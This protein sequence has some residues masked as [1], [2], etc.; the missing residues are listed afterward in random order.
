MNFQEHIYFIA[1]IPPQDICDEINVFKND[2]KNRFHS[3][4]ALKIVPHIT[5]KPPFKLTISKHE[6]L[7]KWF[8]E[9]DF[10][11]KP[12]LQVLDGFG[13]FETSRR[14]VVFV[15]PVMNNSLSQ[16]QQ[17]LLHHF[18]NRFSWIEVRESDRKFKPHITIGYRDLDHRAYIQAWQE[19]KEKHYNSSFEVNEICLLQ[20]KD[21]RWWTIE[22]KEI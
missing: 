7:C 12:F 8:K 19:Y 9:L 20:H 10:S 4:A 2:F 13:S 18:T 1:I 22:R 17:E 6:E 14:P 5:L 11:M 21:G 16:L 15:K 3:Q